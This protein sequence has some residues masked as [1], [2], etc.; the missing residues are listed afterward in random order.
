MNLKRIDIDQMLLHETGRILW[1]GDAGVIAQSDGS[2][3]VLSDVADGA[4][5]R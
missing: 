2:S 5:L 3:L 4:L 1:E